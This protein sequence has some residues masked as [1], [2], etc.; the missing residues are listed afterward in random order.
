MFQNLCALRALGHEVH[1]AVL[2]S[3]DPITDDVRERTATT[4]QISATRTPLAL[5]PL[6]R[7][8][9]PETFPLRFPSSTGFADAVDDLARSLK[10]ALIWAD[11]VWALAAAPRDRYPVVFGNYDFLFKLKTV[12]KSTARR[13]E[14]RDLLDVK[15]LRARI[16]RPDAMTLSTLKSLELRLAGEAAHVMCVS[17]SESEFLQTRGIQSTTIPI[18]GPTIPKPTVV[19]DAKPRFFL[20]GNHNTAHASALAEIRHRLWPAL[21][22]VGG[23]GEWH[24][25]GKPPK[26]PDQDWQ[27]MERSFQHIHGFVDDLATVFRPGDISVVPYRHDTGFRTK[28]TVAAGYGVVSAGYQE[29]FLCAPEFTPS[30]NCIAATTAEDLAATLRRV[31]D[32]HAWSSSLGE[33]ARE[34]YEKTY[35]FEAQLP[36]YAQ[37]LDSALAS[38]RT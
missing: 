25:L 26:R 34:L 11:S 5:R 22:K 27:W 14:P 8:L 9:N 36:R 35:T 33:G 3:N 19:R 31:V 38:R 1:L 16:H 13:L 32:D 24:Q 29:S 28:F 23:P 7:V 10:P 12:R 20:F 21:E 6:A 30:V 37:V 17:A 18:V 15:A 4:H 2:G